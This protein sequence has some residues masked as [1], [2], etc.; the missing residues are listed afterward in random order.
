MGES[1]GSTFSSDTQA[2]RSPEGCHKKDIQ[3]ELGA[4]ICQVDM[5]VEEVEEVDEV[6]AEAAALSNHSGKEMMRATGWRGVAEMAQ[7]QKKSALT[8]V[9]SVE[10]ELKVVNTQLG[11]EQYHRSLDIAPKMS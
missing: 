8:T 9:K 7:S 3:E 10:E 2:F 6:I 5:E 4:T 1:N 11:E